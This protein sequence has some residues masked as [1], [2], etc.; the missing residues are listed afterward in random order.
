M[1]GQLPARDGSRT[2]SNGA[3]L[4]ILGVIGSF[5][6]FVSTFVIFQRDRGPAMHSHRGVTDISAGF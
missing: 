2:H 6:V 5:Q 3:L 1:V 4:T